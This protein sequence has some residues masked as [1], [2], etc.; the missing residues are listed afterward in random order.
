MAI[1]PDAYSAV[2]LKAATPD[3]SVPSGA[4]I[5]G[6]DSQS[7]AAPS[8][9]PLADLADAIATANRTTRIAASGDTTGTADTTAI[10]AAITALSSTGGVVELD[11]AAV[12]YAKGIAPKSN[13]II[14]G[15][16]A[17]I[18]AVAGADAPLVY[19]YS[20]DELTGFS[21]YDVT[22]DGNNVAQD[23]V[24][25]SQPN[26][27]AP[28]KTWTHS[29]LFGVAIVNSA[30]VGIYCPVPGRVRLI[31]CR[32]QYND[33]GV[34]FDREHF[35]AY[36]TSVEYNRIG[37]RSTGNHFV[38]VHSV[39]NHNTEKGWTTQGALGPDTD[40]YEG[41]FIGCTFLDNGD[42]S[43]EGPLESTRIHGCRFGSADYHIV[44][45]IQCP[46]IG[47]T[48]LGAGE[49]AIDELDMR[50]IVQGCYVG[51]GANGIRTKSGATNANITNN[52]IYN[53]AGAAIYL[54][55]PYRVI[56]SGNN[57]TTC[58]AGIV[59]DG[60]S[61]AGSFMLDGN[62]IADI[63][64]VGIDVQGSNAHAI[65]DWSISD[66]KIENTGLEAI[67]LGGTGAG[68]DSN[69]M[70]ICRNGIKDANTSDTES[71]N[72]ILVERLPRRG[73]ISDN[74]IR[75]TTAGKASY[76]I[77]HTFSS[78]AALDLMF[79]GNVAVGMLGANAYAVQSGVTRGT[80]IGT[81]DGD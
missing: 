66:N 64:G 74:V 77:K 60:G 58:A 36:N 41:A 30:A 72:A 57:I 12:Y 44:S 26:P 10:N 35:D 76:A 8:V 73:S 32:I 20:D 50:S 45:T 14:N 63:A 71:I 59:V 56:A 34:A 5:F 24:H 17:T 67:K 68:A 37:V 42:V 3:S 15:R 11:P 23:I 1:D 19:Y 48:F 54:T 6:A 2:D 62:R 52:V 27:A 29:T 22:L 13:V 28:D 38:W 61:P 70:Q 18:K 33:I 78:G 81:F 43:L 47:C 7:A 53:Q 9:Y 65:N 79:A 69:G 51:T 75:N 40:V 31:G 49:W 21:L 80:N 4:L 55:K 46:I 16:Q 25:V 39:I